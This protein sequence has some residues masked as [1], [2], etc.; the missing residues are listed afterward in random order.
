M[1]SLH[2]DVICHEEN[3]IEK[4]ERKVSYA[5]TMFWN[6]GWSQSIIW[7]FTYVVL[8]SLI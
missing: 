8:W 3:R 1:S 4:D 5:D 2:D 6:N 7:T